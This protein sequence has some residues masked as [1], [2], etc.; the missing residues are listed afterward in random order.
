MHDTDA[1]IST[2]FLS[3]ASTEGRVLV[4]AGDC[5]LLSP[6]TGLTLRRNCAWVATAT[7]AAEKL[8]EDLGKVLRG[9]VLNVQNIYRDEEATPGLF[10]A[11]FIAACYANRRGKPK[12]NNAQ[13]S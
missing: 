3:L 2:A 8:S 10:D 12:S 9:A 11:R 6:I 13:A 7:A 1:T 4:G 5:A